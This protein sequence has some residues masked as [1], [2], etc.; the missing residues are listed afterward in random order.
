MGCISG[1]CTDNLSSVADHQ[2]KWWAG[3]EIDHIRLRRRGVAKL[4]RSC[5]HWVQDDR[6]FG[7]NRG[8]CEMGRDTRLVTV[9][10]SECAAWKEA[11]VRNVI[12][13]LKGIEGEAARRLARWKGQAEHFKGEVLA[14]I[15]WLLEQEAKREKEEIT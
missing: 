13:E 15:E 14:E 1:G 7:Y 6:L 9:A 10:N 5:Y 3:Q 8:A 2:S 12:G 4:C 11:I